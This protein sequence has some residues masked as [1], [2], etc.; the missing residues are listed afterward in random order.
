MSRGKDKSFG[1]CEMKRRSEIMQETNKQNKKKNEKKM[2]GSFAH[3]HTHSHTQTAKTKGNFGGE[4][5][6][7]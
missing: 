2:S 6:P 1:Q 5:S 7:V 4:K 3:T